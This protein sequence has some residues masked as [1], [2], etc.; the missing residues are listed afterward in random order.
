MVGL[1]A[2]S[3]PLLAAERELAAQ[4]RTG[5]RRGLRSLMTRGYDYDDDGYY[6]Y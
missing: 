5:V 3:G 1:F 4:G 6:C 2:L